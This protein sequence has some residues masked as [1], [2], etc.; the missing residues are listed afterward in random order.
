MR[1]Y[2]LRIADNSRYL[3]ILI[4]PSNFSLQIPHTMSYEFADGY[5]IRDQYAPH[6]LTFTVQGWVDVFTRKDYRDIL[7]DSFT[8]CQKHKGLLIGGYVIMSNHVHVI[9][10]SP[11]GRLSD[12]VRDFK[13]HTSKTILNE[14]M[15]LPEESRKQWMEYLFGYFAKGSNRNEHYKFWTNNNHPEAIYSA[16]FLMTKL[17]YIHENPVRAGW[18]TNPENYLYSS[19]SNYVTGSGIFQIDPLY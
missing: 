12:I 7:L 13:T 10:T 2:K 19:A 4:T 5:K 18:V 14:L 16:D 15:N 8:Y 6:F 11:D 1:S 9:W 17:Q 3:Q